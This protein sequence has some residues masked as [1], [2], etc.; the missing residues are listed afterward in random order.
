MVI[1]M[2][3]VIGLTDNCNIKP[4]RPIGVQRATVRLVND[5]KKGRSYRRKHNVEIKNNARNDRR[6]P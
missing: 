4:N 1:T 3:K 6:R 5:S 2:H